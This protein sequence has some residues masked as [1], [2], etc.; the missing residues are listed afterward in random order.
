LVNL[1]RNIHTGKIDHPEK[2]SKDVADA[3][4]GAT[5]MASQ[6]AEQ[7]GYEFGESLEIGL[8]TSK[9]HKDIV[10]RPQQG[11]EGFDPNVLAMLRRKRQEREEELDGDGD[12]VFF[13]R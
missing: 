8:H 4:C 12:D 6:S 2:G 13:F 3:L 1:E 7:F 5:W 9:M 10:M 11:D